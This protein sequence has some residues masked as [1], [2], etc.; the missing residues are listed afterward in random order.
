MS[1]V[2]SVSTV[3]SHP[4][5]FFPNTVLRKRR[6]R[7][8]DLAEETTLGLGTS[9]SNDHLPTRDPTRTT[10]KSLNPKTALCKPEVL[11]HG[12]QLKL[13]SGGTGEGGTVRRPDNFKVMGNLPSILS[14]NPKSISPKPLN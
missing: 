13:G 14:L 11:L 1:L 3:E 10:A 2:N 9:R 7:C 6:S 4:A 5:V 12:L 8:C